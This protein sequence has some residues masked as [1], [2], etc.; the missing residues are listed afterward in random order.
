[1]ISYYNAGLKE[2]LL[3]EIKKLNE[4]GLLILSKKNF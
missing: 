2:L 3:D 4:K 1:M